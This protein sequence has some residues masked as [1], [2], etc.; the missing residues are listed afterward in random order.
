MIIWCFSSTIRLLEPKF[1]SILDRSKVLEKIHLV[2]VDD[3]HEVCKTLSPWT[4]KM[5]LLQIQILSVIYKFNRLSTM[6]NETGE[7]E[8]GM[9]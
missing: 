7:R 2:S 3:Y 6:Y 4:V 1:A 9:W 5:L 8:K